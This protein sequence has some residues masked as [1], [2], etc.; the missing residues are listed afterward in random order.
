MS[1]SLVI[2]A[3]DAKNLRWLETVDFAAMPPP[4]GG[5]TAFASLSL[6]YAHRGEE[7]QVT[8]NYG[9]SIKSVKDGLKITEDV[10]SK[11]A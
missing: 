4:G 7:V 10:P 2:A 11:A 8:Q 1:S 9:P 3:W 5:A 6:K